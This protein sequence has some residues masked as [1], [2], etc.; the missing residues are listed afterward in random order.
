LKED[1]HI[2]MGFGLEESMAKEVIATCSNSDLD[3]I[4]GF[5]NNYGE[6][7]KTN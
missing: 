3:T 4:I 7:L 6:F 5:L 1:I 2:L